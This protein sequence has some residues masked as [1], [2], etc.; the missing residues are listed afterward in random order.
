MKRKRVSVVLF[1]Q[2]QCEQKPLLEYDRHEKCKTITMSISV[3]VAKKWC[4]IFFLVNDNCMLA[5]LIIIFCM[6]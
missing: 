5:L 3:V 6:G 2:F 1:A 4:I